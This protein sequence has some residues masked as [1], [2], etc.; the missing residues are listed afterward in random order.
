LDNFLNDEESWFKQIG[1]TGL[2]IKEL[3]IA[4]EMH[5]MIK[6]PEQEVVR[7]GKS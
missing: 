7:F 1:N 3:Q 6:V 4:I 2:A 5:K